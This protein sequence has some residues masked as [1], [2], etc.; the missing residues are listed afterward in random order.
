MNVRLSE[1]QA[2]ILA[3]LTEGL[4][5]EEMA[6]KMYLSPHTTRIYRAQLLE[7]LGARSAAHAVHL[8]YVEGILPGLLNR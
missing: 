2:S 6:R 3:Y 5:N 4:T 1:R 8:A 7:T